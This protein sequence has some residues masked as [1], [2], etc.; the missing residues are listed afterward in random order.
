MAKKIYYAI[1][2]VLGL[3]YLPIAPGTW[4]SLGGLLVC[5][6]LHKYL[7]V[8]LACF[9]ITFFL[10][11]VAASKIEEDTGEKDPS[12]V[13]MDEFACIFP[14]FLFVPMTV[15]TIVVGF[16][17]YR[18]I[19]IIKIPPMGPLE[20]IEGGWGIMLDDLVGG[21]YTNIILQVLILVGL[22]R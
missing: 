7:Y 15:L 5:F 6:L 19:D 16:I 18:I 4:G 20:K 21:I 9:V 17:I 11:V 8:Y 1:G 3:G 22:I 10:G 12:I 2:T 14:V 13:V